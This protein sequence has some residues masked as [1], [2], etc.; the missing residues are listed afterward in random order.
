MAVDGLYIDLLITGND[1]TLDAGGEPAL[2]DDRASIA[3]DIKHLIRESGLMVQIIGQRDAVAVRANLQKL[4]LLVEDD[5][6][7]VPGTVAIA[8]IDAETYYL[9]ADTAAFGPIDFTVGI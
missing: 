2:V 8:A 5:V 3:Q 9:T 7:L 1:L 6:R 4:E